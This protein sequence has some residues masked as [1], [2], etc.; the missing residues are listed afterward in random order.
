MQ[1]R[2]QPLVDS[3]AESDVGNRVGGTSVLRI[4]FTADD[5]ARTTMAATQDI[6]WEVINSIQL[7][8]QPDEGPVHDGWLRTAGPELRKAIGL[9]ETVCPSADGVPDLGTPSWPAVGTED[10][11][12]RLATCL[13]ARSR[14]PET[15]CRIETALRVYHRSV[16]APHGDVIAARL[17]A[18]YARRAGS[19]AHGGTEALLRDFRP[20]MTWRPPVLLVDSPHCRDLHLG[21]RGL[22]LVPAFFGRR[23]PAVF[24]DTDLQ[25]T[26]VYAVEHRVMFDDRSLTAL[27]GSTRAALLETS[28]ASHTTT[29]LARLVGIAPATVSHHIGVLRDARL[30][31]T[32]RVANTAIHTITGL[33]RALLEAGGRP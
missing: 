19:A 1:A 33:G 30:V 15:L 21:G 26:L 20:V 8:R 28:T 32:H 31:S 25:P 6:T 24:A 9:L 22:V 17:R 10:P 29:E 27:L 7:L 14:D 4:H 12:R 11:L 16:L 18:E 23:Y 5:L 13:G 3:H 2:C